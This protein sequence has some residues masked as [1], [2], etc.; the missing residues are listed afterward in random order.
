VVQNDLATHNA[1]VAP[2]DL[3]ARTVTLRLAETFVIARESSD[4]EDVV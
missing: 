3:T 4:E 2:V 1:R